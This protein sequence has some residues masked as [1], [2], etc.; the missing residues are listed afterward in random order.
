MEP[1]IIKN[2]TFAYPGQDN[3]F[4]NCNLDLESSWKLGLLGRNGRGKTTL[5][6]IFQHQLDYRGKIQCKLDFAGFPLAITPDP[7]SF[8]IDSILAILPSLQDEQWKIEREL[9]LLHASSD[10]FYQPYES[11]S[12]GEKTKLQ[13]AALFALDRQ[14]LLLDEPTNHLDQESRHQLADYLKEKKTGFIIT[15]HDRT[16]LDQVIDHCLV[17][18]QHQLVLEHG[19]YS[20]YFEQKQRRDQEAAAANQHLK[21]EIKQLKQK[22]QQRQQ[23][24]QK[25]EKEKKNNAHA[26][27]G[28]IG[29]KAAKMMK[30]ATTMNRRLNDSIDEKRSLIN[31]SERVASL[32]LNYQPAFHQ[33]LLEVKDLALSYSQKLFKPVSFTLANH[34]QLVLIGNNGVGKSSL[35]RAICETFP[36]NISGQINLAHNLKIS[37]VRQDYSANHGLLA[38]FAQEHHL[39]YE[40]LL[41]TLF[42]LG[43]KRET[44]NTPI[45]K[46]SMGQQKRVELAKSL[47]EPAQLYIWDEPLNYLDTY[48]Q[49]QLIRLIKEYQP[50]LLFIEHDENFI[51]RIASKKVELVPA[52]I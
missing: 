15:S 27:K 24:A 52:H 45:E 3:L 7:A 17:I 12:G 2:L 23:W 21:S 9:T 51:E 37:L 13:L 44:F 36:G 5:L 31:E 25:A 11:L 35:I 46:M 50:P 40:D 1:I 38:D 8:A 20:T 49:E 47:V 42:K 26:D 34:E 28:F 14:Y 10:I 19:N 48:N 39:N 16:F 43:F 41:N 6:K 30:K 29:A 22:Q 32:S 33:P 4:E 18:E